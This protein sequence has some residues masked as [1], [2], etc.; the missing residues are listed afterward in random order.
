M[1]N[2]FRILIAAAMV[3]A[4]MAPAGEA[5]D[6]DKDRAQNKSKAPAAR[7]APRKPP[8]AAPAPVAPASEP[9]PAPADVR[10]K[11]AQTQGA[12]VSYNTTY[13]QGRASASSSPGSLRS[14]SAI[15]NSP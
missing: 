2:R 9:A 4:M 13:I 5:Q 8:V 1:V 3:S 15:S 12:Q 6:R 11:T 7:K 14:T 10:L